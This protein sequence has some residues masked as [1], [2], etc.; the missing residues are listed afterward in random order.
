MNE[1]IVTNSTENPQFL[2]TPMKKHM[3]LSGVQDHVICYRRFP[4][5]R[6]FYTSVANNVLIDQRL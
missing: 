3:F 4:F 1:N 5:P 2:F 6:G